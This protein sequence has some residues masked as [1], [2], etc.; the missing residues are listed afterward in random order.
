MAFENY[1][2]NEMQFD[3]LKEIGNIGS[4]HAA[5]ALSSMLDRPIDMNVPQINILDYNDV[6]NNL[7]GPENVLAGIL[8]SLTGDVSGMIMFLIHKPF[9]ELL[10]SNLLGMEVE[11]LD[12]DEMSQSALKEVGNIIAASYVNAIAELTGLSIEISPPELC[13]DMVG[14]VLSLPAIY[15]ANIS[16]KII[17]IK[18]ELDKEDAASSQIILIPDVDSLKKIMESLGLADI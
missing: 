4:G 18:D 17:F 5:S 14:S 6:V 11:D 13:I 9:V 3:A 15:Y 16:D 12:L 8:M 2:L 7:G 10:L 1:E